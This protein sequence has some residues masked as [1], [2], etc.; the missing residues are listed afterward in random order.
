MEEIIFSEQD[1]VNAV[2]LSIAARKKIEP[3]QVNVE[4]LYD[5]EYGFSAEVY[6]NGRKQV[7]V[8]ANLIEAVRQYI[9][10]EMDGD[11]Y[12]AS[13]RMNYEEPEGISISCRL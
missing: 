5:D 6:T 13:L 9:A 4:L 3:A 1:I 7:L 8:E 12:A 10:Q 11:P 2:C